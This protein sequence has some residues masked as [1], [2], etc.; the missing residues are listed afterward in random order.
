M[1]QRLYRSPDDRV[2]AGIAGGMAETYALDPAL[3]RV[4]WAL[5]ILISGGVFLILYIVMALVVPLRPAGVSLWAAAGP[6]GPT[7]G[8]PPFGGPGGGPNDQTTAEGAVPPGPGMPPGSGMDPGAPVPGSGYGA[9]PDHR[10]ARHDGGATGVL[11][12]GM[13]LVLVGIFFLARQLLPALN[14]GL[15]WPVV[16]IIGGA[17]LVLAAF[18]RSGRDGR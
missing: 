2:L 4:G 13:L 18:R 8:G 10:P 12:I 3:V 9:R 6:G 14:F 16:V 15:I 7:F 5:L 1:N 17:L 11:V